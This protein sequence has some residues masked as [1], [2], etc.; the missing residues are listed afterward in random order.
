M[1]F[2]FCPQCGEKLRPRVCGDEGEVPYC[3]SCKRPFFP[4]SYP[5]VICLCITE[6]GSEIALIRQ[7]YVSENYVNVAGYVKRGETPESAAVREIKEEIGL[8]AVSVSYMG[9][10]Y[11]AKSDNLMLGFECRVKKGELILS[12]EVD[13][14]GWFPLES[15]RKLLRRG[16]IGMNL[17][18][19]CLRGLSSERGNG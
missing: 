19:E 17:L 11:H 16:S 14:A 4:F 1:D 5:C 8:D 2:S 7:S 3:E 13:E 6:D 12:S 15:A 9:S 18:E 10:W